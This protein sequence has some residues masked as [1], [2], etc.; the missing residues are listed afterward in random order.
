VHYLSGQASTAFDAVRVKVAQFINA[1]AP[2]EVIFTR[3]T[4]DAINLVAQSYGK[5]FFRAGD[6]VLI[7]G[8]E[9]HSNIV[10]WQLVCEQTGA[11]LRA[12]PLT[13]TG[14]LDLEQFSR[15]LNDRTRFVA[16]V[17][18]SNALGIINPVREITRWARERNIPC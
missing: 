7:T 18:L 16:L 13:E 2:H 6:E 9:H 10:P 11:V 15:L 4:T 3:G 5:R 17:H 12:A 8:M 1:R 14:G